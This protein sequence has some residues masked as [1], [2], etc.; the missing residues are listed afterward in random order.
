[1]NCAFSRHNQLAKAYATACGD[2]DPTPDWQ[3][4]RT[5]SIFSR[6]LAT[7]PRICP[8]LPSLK[9]DFPLSPILSTKT[10]EA[11]LRR[12]RRSLGRIR[13][14]KKSRTTMSCLGGHPLKRHSA[15]RRRR[16]DPTTL[17]DAAVVMP[18]LPLGRAI[19]CINERSTLSRP[20]WWS[21]AANRSSVSP[22]EPSLSDSRCEKSPDACGA[23]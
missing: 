7:P 21:L 13:P 14:P 23:H 16:T 22:D 3:I 12:E 8:N 2:C 15:C 4:V 6:W 11:A 9:K 19:L 20:R 5:D 10:T 17:G 1:V 18:I